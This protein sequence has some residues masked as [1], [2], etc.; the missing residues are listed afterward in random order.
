MNTQKSTKNDDGTTT[1]QIVTP[2][3]IVVDEWTVQ[4]PTHTW[5]CD[6]GETVKRYRGA[7]EVQCPKCDQWFNSAGQRLRNDWAGNRSN[8]DD[9]MGD[10]EGYEAQYADW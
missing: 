10:L 2:E 6:C 3:G 7:R 9:D 4:G 1:Y 8:W 5:E